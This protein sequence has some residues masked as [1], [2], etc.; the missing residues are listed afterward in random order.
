MN[1]E[2][3]IEIA[4]TYPAMFRDAPAVISGNGYRAIA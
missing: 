1:N 2:F 3:A 4:E